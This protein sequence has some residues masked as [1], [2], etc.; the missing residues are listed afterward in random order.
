MFG[1]FRQSWNSWRRDRGVAFFAIVALAI[2]I[3]CS[4]AIFTVV[5]AVLL[6]PLPYSQGERWVALFSGTTTDPNSLN[7]IGGLTLAD[8]DGYQQHT[9]SFDLFGWF[10]I[11]GDFNLTS[12]GS[13]RHI[14]GIEVSPSL[15][16]GTGVPPLAGRT[17]TSADQPDVALISQRLFELLGPG[18]MITKSG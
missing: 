12:P 3:G 18:V 10:T 11:G 5:H 15:I 8:L 6:K 16:A 13:P 14:E 2:G 1:L 4:T 7:H 9:R 17:F